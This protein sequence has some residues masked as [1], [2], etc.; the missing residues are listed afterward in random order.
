MRAGAA[1]AQGALATFLAEVRQLARIA[2][3]NELPEDVAVVV[4]I[5]ADIGRLAQDLSAADLLPDP[6][7][8]WTFIQGICKAEPCLTVTDC[9]SGHQAVDAKIRREH[10]TIAA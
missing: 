6:E 9:G 1:G 8:L 5:F 7:H 10:T 3:K 4:H 2:H